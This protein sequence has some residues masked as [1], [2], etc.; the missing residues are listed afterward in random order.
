MS[1]CSPAFGDGPGSARRMAARSGRGDRTRGPKAGRASVLR[2]RKCSSATISARLRTGDAG[3]PTA[4]SRSTISSRFS[5]ASTAAI[6]AAQ[7]VA[8]LDL[9]G[10][11]EVGDVVEPEPATERGPE[12]RLGDHAERDVAVGDLERAVA[13]QAVD[14][15]ADALELPAAHGARPRREEIGHRHVDRLAFTGARG[16]RS[17]RRRSRTLRRDHRRGRPTGRGARARVTA[18]HPPA[19]TRRPVP[20]SSRRGR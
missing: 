17:T 14:R 12:V 5:S 19:T 9:A 3:A 4:T 13:G 1:W 16:D 18:R 2:S 15:S 6:R 10:D 20:G 7:L 11:V 8:P